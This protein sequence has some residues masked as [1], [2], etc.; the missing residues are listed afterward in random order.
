MHGSAGRDISSG[1]LQFRQARPAPRAAKGE[2]V[3]PLMDCPDRRLAQ[4]RL[5]RRSAHGIALRGP[6]ARNR[7]LGCL[8]TALCAGRAALARGGLCSEASSACHSRSGGAGI[9]M[10]PC[11]IDLISSEKIER[12]RH[13]ASISRRR[14]RRE[15]LIDRAISVRSRGPCILCGA[16]FVVPALWCPVLEPPGP[17]VGTFPSRKL[18]YLSGLRHLG[19]GPSSRGC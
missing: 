17:R 8:A 1:R 15:S 16:R 11:R 13:I 4:Y 5:H 9:L 3:R 14:G 10:W 7:D 18:A 2:I 12:T 19:T 6:G